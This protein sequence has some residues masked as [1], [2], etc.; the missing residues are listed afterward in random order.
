ME[1]IVKIFDQVLYLPLLN[2]LIWI[3]NILPI[4]DLGIAIIILTVLIRFIL[5]PLSKKSIKSQKAMSKLQPEIKKIQKKFKNKEEQAKEMMLLYKKHKINPAAGCLPILVQFPVLIALY[6]VFFTGLN[7][8]NMN[9][10]YG[11]IQKPEMLNFMFLGLFDLSQRSIILALLAGGLQFIQ[12]KMIMPKKSVG[13]KGKSSADF[14]SAM[15]QQMMYFMPIITVFIAWKL[16]A[17]LPLYWI[18]IT[19][20]G[21]I[22]QHF[23]KNEIETEKVKI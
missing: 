19:L 2:A 9:N 3:Y 18:V 7:L 10:L 11:F 20:F 6:R 1:I 16:P 4:S 15:G 5:Y 14:A 22:Q 23:T 12:S 8:E 21:I 17:A 13:G